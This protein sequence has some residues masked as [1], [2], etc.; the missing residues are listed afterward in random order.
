MRD[1]IASIEAGV[2][3]LPILYDNKIISRSQASVA[4]VNLKTIAAFG[5]GVFGQASTYI[6]ASIVVCAGHSVFV[7]AN[8]TA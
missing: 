1:L 5:T 4:R 6:T 2:P 7:Q 8:L 3:A